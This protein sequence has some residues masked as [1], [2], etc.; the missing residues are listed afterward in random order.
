MKNITSLLAPY[1]LTTIPTILLE[2]ILH[3]TAKLLSHCIR[4]N[5]KTRRNK[6]LRTADTVHR[7]LITNDKRHN[8]PTFK[9]DRHT[10]YIDNNATTYIS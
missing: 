3:D 7:L 4:N 1:N 10:I 6:Q 9:P 2:N 5:L 8:L